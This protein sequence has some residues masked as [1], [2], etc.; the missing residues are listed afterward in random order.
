ML[1]IINP[2]QKSISNTTEGK[3]TGKIV[4]NPHKEVSFL[5]QVKGYSLSQA[6]DYWKSYKKVPGRY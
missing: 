2:I 1:L 6:I 3:E 4:F 5:E